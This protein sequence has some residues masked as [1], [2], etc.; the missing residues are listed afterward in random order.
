MKLF[1]NRCRR[2]TNHTVIQS[3]SQTYWHDDDPDISVDYAKH[4][5]EI[6]QCAGCELVSF[7]EILSTSE[8]WE[9][10]ETRY[11][12]ADKDQLVVKS[13]RQ[14]SYN[15]NRIYRESIRSFNIGNYILCTAGLRAVIEAICAKANVKSGLVEK[16][17]GEKTYKKKKKNLEGKIEGLHQKGI[18]L[19]KHA[20]ILHAL[21]FIG[22]DAVHELSTPP[23]DD[24]KEAIEIVERT[25]ENLYE[26]P[27]MGYRLLAKK[28]KQQTS[29][30]D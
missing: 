17:E 23:I 8:E 14:A 2:D 13:F 12:E 27:E 15:I 26:L 18:L 28:T 5:W 9:P 3:H 10:T 21:R 19:K 20:E 22:N 25:I 24:L 11:P 16:K 29:R 4:T 30:D 6:I 7:R 1:C